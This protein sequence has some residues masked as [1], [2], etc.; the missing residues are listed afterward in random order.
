MLISTK[1]PVLAKFCK[2]INK[3]ATLRN[4]DIENFNAVDYRIED[5][6]R[7]YNKSGEDGQ[8]LRASWRVWYVDIREIA[9]LYIKAVKKSRN[10]KQ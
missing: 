4:I 10:E 7:V 1:P 3:D 8:E 9:K 2:H 6:A 5:L